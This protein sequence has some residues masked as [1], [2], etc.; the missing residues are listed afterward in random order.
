MVRRV[1]SCRRMYQLATSSWPS[2]LTCT[3]SWITSSRIRIVSG[4]SRLAICQTCSMSWWEPSTSLACRPPSIHTTAFPSRASAWAS[5]SV[6]PSARARL[7][8]LVDPHPRARVQPAVD[9][10]PRLPLPGQ[11]GGLVV[12][13][14]LR[15]GQAGRDLLVA[16]ELRHVRGAGDDHHVL[17]AALGGLPDGDHPEPGRLAR[18]LLPVV[19]Q[20]GVVGQVVVVAHVPAELLLRRSD[21]GLRGENGGESEYQRQ[22]ERQSG[23]PGA[24][25]SI[26]G[27]GR[28]WGCRETLP[29]VPAWPNAKI[30]PPRDGR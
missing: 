17:V 4:S 28:S 8:G 23:S 2:G 20:L 29:G 9:P 7:G 18:Q 22:A 30:R 25:K 14:P 16:V 26:Y 1:E 11:R 27:H 10:P 3:R 21:V 15:A 24:A 19:H 12:G 13:E 6:S 5:S